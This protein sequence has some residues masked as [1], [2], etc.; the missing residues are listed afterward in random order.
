MQFKTIWHEWQ[1]NILQKMLKIPSHAYLFSWPKWIWKLLIAKDFTKWLI[2]NWKKINFQISEQLNS[3]EIS[4]KIDQN[5]YEDL[6]ILDKLWIDWEMTDLE[7]ISK[8]TNLSQEHRIK[9]KPSPKTNTISNWDIHEI[10]KQANKSSINWRK[11]IIIRDIER[12]NQSA[13][14]SFLKTL[15]QPPKDTIF[16]CTSSNSQ[17][18]APTILSRVQELKF[19]FLTNSQIKQFLLENNK[20]NLD[21]TELDEIVKY[22]FW[23]ISSAKKLLN[24]LWDLI[25]TKDLFNT[26]EKIFNWESIWFKIKRA[27]EVV[28]EKEILDKELE[29]WYYFLRSRLFD[30][31]YKSEMVL[32]W[33]NNLLELRKDFNYNLNKRLSLEN[34]YLSF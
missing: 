34:F 3:N 10:I 28:L 18:L 16:L 33:L 11:I 15:E 23:R 21:E 14:N 17:K 13:F 5:I 2:L 19:N 27:W 25:I 31:S 1:K 4:R 24:N 26:V 20:S 6:I 12:M 9:K 8:Y 22:S 29:V 7:E 30:I 32:N